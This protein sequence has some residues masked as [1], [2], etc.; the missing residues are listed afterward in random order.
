MALAARH[1]DFRKRRMFWPLRWRD[2][3]DLVPAT[4]IIPHYDAFPEPMSA[5]VVLQAPR[6]LVTLGIDEDTALVGRDGSWQV[7]GRGRVTVW[8]GRHRQ[9]YRAGDV[10]RI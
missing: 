9:R 8:R 1:W 6:G 4:A 5:M 2:G 10:F 3:L 7:Q